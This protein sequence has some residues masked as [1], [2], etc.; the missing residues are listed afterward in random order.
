MN[1]GDVGGIEEGVGRV[2]GIQR[3]RNLEMD[4][5]FALANFGEQRQL[6]ERDVIAVAHEHPDDSLG[7]LTG[8][9][10]VVETVAE[11]ALL[12]AQAGNGG[13]APVRAE[14]PAMVVAL[15][16]LAVE[17]AVMQGRA[18][19]RAVVAHGEDLA[20]GGAGQQHALAQKRDG[21]HLAGFEIRSPQT[22][23][24][25]IPQGRDVVGCPVG[26]RQGGM[27]G[28]VGWVLGPHADTSKHRGQA[29]GGQVFPDA[30]L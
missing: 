1:E 6:G 25:K 2:L 5:W 15:H 28:H 20:F 30:K 23:I 16:I 21:L 4:L 29:K 9:G 19:M 12:D 10:L 11:V 18:A 26:R 7:L 14:F 17:L 13:A 27:G 22:E 8:V 3:V 24:P